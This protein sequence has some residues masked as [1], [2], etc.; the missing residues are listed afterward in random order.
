MYPGYI[1]VANAEK[2]SQA[3]WSFRVANQVEK[4]HAGLFSKTVNNLK[5]G[6]DVNY[7]VV[8]FVGIL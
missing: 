5:S 7:Y 8:R 3:V 1:D 2:N 4:I 6:K